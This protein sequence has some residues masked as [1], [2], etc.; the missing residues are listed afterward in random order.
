MKR[1]HQCGRT[2]TRGFTTAPAAT[3]D[4]IPDIEPFEVGPFVEC[5]SKA[6][7]RKRW[8]KTAMEDC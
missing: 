7:C 6:A 1:C 3:V 5:A 2:G 4:Y 8:P